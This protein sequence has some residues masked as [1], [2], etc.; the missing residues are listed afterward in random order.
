MQ[1]RH[2]MKWYSWSHYKHSAKETCLHTIWLGCM[3]WKFIENMQ[4]SWFNKILCLKVKIEEVLNLVCV[5]SVCRIGTVAARSQRHL[6]SGLDTLN[7]TNAD[8]A[9]LSSWQSQQDALFRGSDCMTLILMLCSLVL[10]MC[11]LSALSAFWLFSDCSL[12]S[13]WVLSISSLNA[14]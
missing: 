12:T 5:T 2:S 7:Q 8:C 10:S 3:V 14:L 1:A 11:S 13:L 9:S 6:W 4:F